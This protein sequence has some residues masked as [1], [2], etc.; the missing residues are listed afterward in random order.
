M[1]KISVLLLTAATCAAFVVLSGCEGPAGE[2]GASTTPANLEGFAPGIKCGT[3][4][5]VDQD[6]T[7]YVAGREYQWE[8]SVHAT[9]GNSERNGPSCAGCHTTQGFI[10]RINGEA[11]TEQLNPT[12]PGCFA[13]H[14]PHMRGNFSLRIADPV[15]LL[16][17]VAGEPD[18][19]FDY[20]KGN[21][22]A[23]CHQPRAMNPKM[24]PN[25]PGDSLVIATPRW[26]PHHGPQSTVL[27]GFG[28]FH[29]PS[30]TYTGN[31]FHT[32]ATVIKQEGCPTCHMAEGSYPPTL[33]TGKGGGHTMNIA[34]ESEGGG[35]SYMLNGCKQSGCHASISSPDYNGVQ[36]TV[37]ANLD[38]LFTMLGNRGWIDTVTTSS[39]Y[40]LVKL[41]NGR[42]VISPA[43]KAG[44][45]YN[46]LLVEEDKSMGVHNSTYVIELLRSSIEEL[47]QP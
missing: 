7:Y 16:S 46:Y 32:D 35:E 43:I 18:A 30:Y 9:G 17:N 10:Q 4:H 21:L 33:G 5:T 14:S 25:P 3:C 12:Q 6:T 15:T 2:P 36:T 45:L 13:C 41:T 19:Q 47:R 8:H 38:T 31:S 20:G 40:G 42:L 37:E 28:G 23:Q 1:K 26:E 44:A 39:T 11:V 24:D 27:M 22:C 29:F 34:F